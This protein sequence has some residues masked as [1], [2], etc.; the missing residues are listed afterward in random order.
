MDDGTEIRLYDRK[1]EPPEWTGM[2][3]GTQCVVFLSDV[4]TSEPLS[5]EGKPFASVGEATCVVFERLDHAQRFCEST[6]NEQPN[7]SCEVFDGQGRAH[8]PMLVVI[9]PSQQRLDDPGGRV[10]RAQ[11]ADC[12]TA[13]C[14]RDTVILDRLA[15]QRIDDTTHVS[16]H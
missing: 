9:H 2:V 11:E 16:G 7:V 5:R 10:V 4:N 15:E 8:P 14:G 12:R 6:V 13:V 1:R 3:L